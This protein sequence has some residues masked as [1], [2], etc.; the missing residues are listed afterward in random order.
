VVGWHRRDVS[1]GGFP[2]PAGVARRG[3]R[4]ESE[5]GSQ[6]PRSSNGIGAEAYPLYP[7]R[8]AGPT[9]PSA[10]GG[11]AVAYVVRGRAD[12]GMVW[13]RAMEI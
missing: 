2:L 1:R 10:C 7:L 3:G 4:A 12:V 5:A 6:G 13:E 11:G 9:A 8:L